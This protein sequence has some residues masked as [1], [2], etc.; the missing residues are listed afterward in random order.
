MNS[1][2]PNNTSYEHSYSN[3]INY[4]QLRSQNDMKTLIPTP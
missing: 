4:E 2:D 1:Y 3:I